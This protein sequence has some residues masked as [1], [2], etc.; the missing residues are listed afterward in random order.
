MSN[1]SKSIAIV[2]KG[3]VGKTSMSSLIIRSLMKNKPNSRILAIDADPAVG[4]STALGIEVKKTIDE[5]RQEVTKAAE[6]GKKDEAVIL[7]NNLSYE[8]FNALTEK[9]NL[10]FL[11]VGRPESEGCYCKVNS[12]LRDI[13]KEVSNKFDY[14]VIDGEAGIEQINRRVMETVSHLIMVSDASQKGINVLKTIKAVSKKL[15]EYEEIGAIINRVDEK[16]VKELVDMK[17]IEKFN[18]IPEDNN[19]KLSDIKGDS[20]L[21]MKTTISIEKI[22]EFLKTLKVI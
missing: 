20:I 12:F 11:A 3:G 15:V 21:D 7:L 13:I 17:W 19:I 4:L 2:G 22:D 8:V 18:V 5:I 16:E 10:A 9:E 14:V 6:L 1:K